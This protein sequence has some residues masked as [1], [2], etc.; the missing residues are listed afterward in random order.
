MIEN[1]FC[2]PIYFE[3]LNEKDFKSVQSEVKSLLKIAE[4]TKRNNWGTNNHSLTSPMFDTNILQEYEAFKFLSI[5]KQNAIKYVTN[6]NG[7][8]DYDIDI[9]TSWITKTL[10]GEYALPHAHG[11]SDIAGVYYFQSNGA[12][13]SINFVNPS[14]ALEATKLRGS[15]VKQV[16]YNPEVGRI[17][18]FP[19]WLMHYVTENQTDSE[20]VSVSFNITLK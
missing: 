20:R 2:T 9:T 3:D 18:L 7:S 10:K 11:D 19:G 15:Q 16:E 4:F 12:D 13:G 1:W 17:I 8:C 6:L 5:I 14:P